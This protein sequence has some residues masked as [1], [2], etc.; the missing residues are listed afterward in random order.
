LLLGHGVLAKV[1]SC[2]PRKLVVSMRYQDEG[3]FPMYEE[4]D[5]T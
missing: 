2:D 3:A 4:D 5:C 1:S